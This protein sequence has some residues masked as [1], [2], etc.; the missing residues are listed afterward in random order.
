ME[1]YQTKIKK[2][3]G[4]NYREIIRQVNRIYKK[5]EKQTKRKMYVRSAYFSKEKVF[6]DYFWAHIKK[7]R[8]GD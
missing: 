6:F 1:Y 5:I 3:P 7:T 8:Y 2:I 4:S